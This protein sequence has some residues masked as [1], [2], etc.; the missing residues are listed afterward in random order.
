MECVLLVRKLAVTGL[1]NKHKI[2]YCFV[3]VSVGGF[4]TCRTHL[5]KCSGTEA[6]WS[7]EFAIPVE[8]RSA[9]FRV[10]GLKEK[11]LQDK[12]MNLAWVELDTFAHLKCST[13]DSDNEPW[14][15]MVMPLQ[16]EG[17]GLGDISFEAKVA[18]NDPIT[19]LE[20]W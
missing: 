17:E 19:L 5:A 7:D 6:R 2:S 14:Q 8:D 20:M 16:P 12:T 13:P 1:K 11:L 18:P 4:L 10:N 15:P 3:K 9:L